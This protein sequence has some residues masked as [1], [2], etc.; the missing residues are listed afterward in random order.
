MKHREH[1]PVDAFDEEYFM[2][3]CG[4]VDAEDPDLGYLGLMRMLYN[5]D[6]DSSTAHLIPNDDNRI[7]DALEM[8]IYYYIEYR[9]FREQETFESAYFKRC[10]VLEMLIALGYRISDSFCRYD[11]IY[12][13]WEMMRNIGLE[14][15]T[16]KI[17]YEHGG[18][19]RARRII[20][21]FMDRKYDRDGFGGLFPVTKT[22]QD[23]RKTELWYQANYYFVENYM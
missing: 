8:K 4:L 3:L 6:F 21:N 17:F 23:Q 16:D 2:W 18:K 19:E 22:S 14:T 11:G 20:R 15:C 9:G 7:E 5:I 12:W 13:F 1:I 10:S